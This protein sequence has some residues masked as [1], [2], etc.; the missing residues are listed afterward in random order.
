MILNNAL[1]NIKQQL[2]ESINSIIDKSY[3]TEKI[4][5]TSAEKAFKLTTALTD[6]P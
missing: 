3:P 5:N 4:I 2:E 6:K 1:E